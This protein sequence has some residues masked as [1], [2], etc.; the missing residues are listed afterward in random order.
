[1][2]PRL[3]YESF[4][5]Q[6]RRKLLAGIA[7]TLGIAVATAMIAVA[8]D[9]GDKINRE[10][11]SYGA[12]LV[13]TPQEDT[14]DVE[15]GGVNLKPPSD[16]AFLSEADLPKIRG[17]FWHNNIV[18]FSPMLP[19][20][21]KLGGVEDVTLAG[22]YFNKPLHFGKEDF[23]TGV[24]I[25]HPWWKV[26][27]DGVKE[28]ANCGWPADDSQNVLLG[29]RLAA[30]VKRKAGDTIEIA[31]RPLTVVAKPQTQKV[32]INRVAAA[33]VYRNKKSKRVQTGPACLLD[34]FAL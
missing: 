26:S 22:T 11:R 17:T 18:G 20:T 9:I 21:V 32:I 27:C 29:E 13:I 34:C 3:V 31:G 33:T 1:M 16:G 5:H 14:L 10:L 25:T 6:G 4:R 19:V 24:R 2:F 30:R 7:I 23:I 12:N 28:S 8:T 15:V